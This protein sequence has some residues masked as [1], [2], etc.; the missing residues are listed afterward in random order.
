MCEYSRI[1][2]MYVVLTYSNKRIVTVTVTM[3][4]TVT[5]T[6]TVTRTTI[7]IRE[8]MRTCTG[9]NGHTHVART[10]TPKKHIYFKHAYTPQ[11][12]TYTRSTHTH[13]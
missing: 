10:Y 11:E 13:T 4:V 6:V 7:H 8:E 12:W 9:E 1:L 2:E 5:V 3:T